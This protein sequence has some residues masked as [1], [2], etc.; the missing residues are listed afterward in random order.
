MQ[1]NLYFSIVTGV[2]EFLYNILYPKI[3]GGEFDE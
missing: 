2:K 1:K 3:K